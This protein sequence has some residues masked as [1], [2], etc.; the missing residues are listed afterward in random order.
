MRDH[1]SSKPVFLTRD[2]VRLAHFEAGPGKPQ[3]PPLVLIN[4]WTGDHGIFTPQIDHFARRRRVVAV[5]LRGHGAS[6]APVQEYTMAGFAD[7]IAWQCRQLGLEK[8]VVI[9]H[10]LGGAIALELCGRHP[11]LASGMMMIDSIVMPPP[12]VRDS[13]EIHRLL[14][15]IG[16]P[17][18]LAVSRAS[19]WDIGCDFDD[20]LRRKVIYDRY[21]L[22]PCE[23]TPQHVAY[24]TIR[25]AVLNHDPVP[26]ARAC[27]IPMAYISA[28]VPLVNMA[29]DLQRLQE[30]C[31]QLVVAKTLLAGH[32]STIEVAD[33]INA[34]ID[35]FLA[36]GMRKQR[37]GG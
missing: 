25:N 15:G 23:K 17:D 19:A 36:V 34:M 28:D 16:G 27:R 37:Q 22:P 35:R 32:F 14:D 1:S 24:S 7:D 21:I 10:S 33:Q 2:G 4:G 8:P 26:A 13:A 3:D 6:D 5:N 11:D 31:P 30:L 20:P 29:R 18:Y 9:G 12:A